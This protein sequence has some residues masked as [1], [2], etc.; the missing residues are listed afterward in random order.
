L[1][2]SSILT[3]LAGLSTGKVCSKARAHLYFVGKQQATGRK[4]Y[5]YVLSIE[6]ELLAEK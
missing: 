5:M 2:V 4:M 6:D 1:T 3:L